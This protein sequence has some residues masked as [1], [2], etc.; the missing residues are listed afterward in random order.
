MSYKQGLNKTLIR[1]RIDYLRN[2]KETDLRAYVR[3]IN[4]LEMV[5]YPGGT[6]ARYD[7]ITNT[8]YNQ[9]GQTLKDPEDYQPD[10]DGRY[11]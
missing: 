4:E 5:S 9:C 3:E 2:L 7:E 8:Y 11:Y 10:N 1:S 6:T